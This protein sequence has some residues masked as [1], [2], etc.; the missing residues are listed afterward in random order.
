MLSTILYLFP[1]AVEVDR[2]EV[3]DI[4]DVVVNDLAHPHISQL[5]HNTTTAATRDIAHANGTESIK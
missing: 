5:N 4:P 2:L 1:V 3:E